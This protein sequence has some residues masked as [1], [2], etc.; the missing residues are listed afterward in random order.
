MIRKFVIRNF[1]CLRELELE[2]EPLTVLVGPN[3]SGKSAVM[4]ALNLNDA[5]SVSTADSWR[6]MMDREIVR[7]WTTAEGTTGGLAQ[8]V[9]PGSVNLRQLGSGTR[10]PLVQNLR[11][12]PNN[13]R[14]RNQVVRAT[15]LDNSGGNLANVFGTLTRKEK[16]E[17]AGQLCS[18]VPLFTDL[19]E[20]PTDTPGMRELRFQDRWNS[21]LWYTPAEVSDGTMLLTGF[22]MLQYQTPPVDL[23]A[24]EEPE[25]SLHPYLLE[26]LVHMLRQL[27]RGDIGRHP[28]Q[29]VLATHSPDLLEYV[30]P[31][32]VRFL[33]RDEGDGSTTVKSAPAKDPDWKRY[34]E[35][36]EESLRRAWLSGGLGGVPGA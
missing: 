36:Y 17:V 5:L 18:L 7:E 3:G 26:Q 24:I 4:A 19:D 21:H 11:L 23:I 6:H 30:Q 16:I 9:T 28:V 10:H 14:R 22:L 1:R 32:E 20:T 15:Q 35:E 25:R 31:E 27:S 12:D 33:G 8:E 2:F 29:V 34:F 13:L